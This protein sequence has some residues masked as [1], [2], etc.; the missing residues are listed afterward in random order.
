[1]KYSLPSGFQGKAGSGVS[2]A[3]CLYFKNLLE[4]GKL[5]FSTFAYQ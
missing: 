3:G 2:P 4:E 5:N 1:M